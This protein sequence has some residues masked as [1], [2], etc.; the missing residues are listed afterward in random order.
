M[1]IFLKIICF[2][3]CAVLLLSTFLTSCNN[4]VDKSTD[5]DTEKDATSNDTDKQGET[6]MDTPNVDLSGNLISSWDFCGAVK[7]E[8]LSDKATNGT[9]LEYITPVGDGT[10]VDYGKLIVNDG[11]GN[12]AVIGNAKGA[13]L[14]DLA[15]TTI[16][17]K[18]K[19]TNIGTNLT[20][21]ILS[22][23][24]CFDLYFE[25][26]D[27]GRPVSFRYWLNG[28]M[29]TEQSNTTTPVGEYR[30]FAVSFEIDRDA[31]TA[32]IC[33]YR[34]RSE[35]PSSEAGYERIINLKLNN[36]PNDFGVGD[37]AIYLG[38]RV[39]HLNQ[40]RTLTSEFLG[41]K[42]Y[43]KVLEKSELAAV[44]FEMDEGTL[45]EMLSGVIASAESVQKTIHSDAEWSM[46]QNAISKGKSLNENS[47]VEELK[48]A[49]SVIQELTARMTIKRVPESIGDLLK[50][51]YN[52]PDIVTPIYVS[53][54]SCPGFYDIDYDGKMDLVVTGFGR[55]YAGV[56]GGSSGGGMYVYRNRT[57]T[58]GDVVLETAEI[59]QLSSAGHPTYSYKKDGSSVFVTE[60][61]MMYTEL[62]NQGYGEAMSFSK[63][64]GSFKLYDVDGDGLSDAVYV[65]NNS[66]GT[67]DYDSNGNSLV[68]YKSQMYWIRNTGSE[69][70]PK[71]AVE[72]K[73]FY[74][75]SGQILTIEDP[76]QY[77]FIRS[78]SMFDWDGDGDLDLIAGGWLNEFYY[79]EN[80][81]TKTTPKFKSQGVKVET[82]SGPM[83]LD[84]CR[85]NIINYDWDGDG[86]DDLVM[87]S[88]SGDVLYFRFT[89][90]FNAETGAPI[91]EDQK[92]F[93]TK[94][95]YLSVSSLSRPTACDFDG[96]GD[97]D[98]IV[99]ESAGFFYFIENL[100]G[101]TEPK[102]AAP[103][104]LTDENGEPIVIKA[105]YNGSLQ[106]TQETEW[107]Y[108]IP[109][110]CDW[111]GDG[112]IDIIAN[113]ITGRIVWLENIGTA[114]KP[115]LTQPKAVEVEWENGSLY[116]KEQWWKP[117]G[118][119][120]V[121]QHRTTPYAVDLNGDGLCD[122]VMLD[123]EGYLAFYERYKE[124]GVLKLKQGERI[125]LGT[126]GKPI[127]L[128]NTWSGTTEAGGI[129]RIKIAVTDWDGDGKL[130][131]LVGKNNFEWYRTIKIQD[132]KYYLSSQGEVAK[133]NIEGHNHGFTVCDWN[134]DGKPDIIT[135]TESGYFY[136]FEHK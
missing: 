46:F 11:A 102:W 58:A 21:G 69:S 65:K 72:A 100:T 130:D 136:Y 97:L 51:K 105:G 111:D 52:N 48:E 33:V 85:Y 89:G 75:E 36:I 57:D 87:G 135:G 3:L 91:F 119:E 64:K 35:N 66:T 44:S 37:G 84:C 117:E 83:A 23:E 18:A 96:D 82:E 1:R 115:Q 70:N 4:A 121:T 45:L 77:A 40:A 34:S 113:S 114:T 94:A 110:A 127:H 41:I 126:D 104:K 25:N 79:Y 5:S 78:F 2:A 112:D 118:K 19:L 67:N 71:F 128:S 22:K 50:I 123:H 39:D 131:I 10:V 101:G 76:T 132:G 68:S 62:S 32:N 12:Y 7:E 24:N 129:G 116:P 99:G 27:S 74:D 80:I 61:G 124:N 98:L 133:G 20:S 42:L 107:G 13:D 125:F 29:V 60:D 134:A 9:S 103:V 31:K 17:F 16:V 28:S 56:S 122:L 26:G 53:A 59:L 43:N 90:R 81:G 49:C 14:Y 54:R 95:E 86:K 92:N 93:S 30:I 55:T 109:V 38:K 63:L 47:T 106:G 15:N 108:T 120:L 6:D 88:D 8:M 73:P